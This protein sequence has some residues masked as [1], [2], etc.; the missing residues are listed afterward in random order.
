MQPVNVFPHQG[1]LKTR[2]VASMA[3]V[4]S[5]TSLPIENPFSHENDNNRCLLE[6]AIYTF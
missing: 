5:I 1:L 6:K 4:H 3:Q 2:C